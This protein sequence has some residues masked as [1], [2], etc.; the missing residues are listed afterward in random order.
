MIKECAWCG[1]SYYRM[2]ELEPAV[3]ATKKNPQTGQNMKVMAR[4]AIS[5]PVCRS[6][7]EM[8]DRNREEQRQRQEA[9]RQRRRQLR[10]ERAARR[11]A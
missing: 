9:E 2:A 10:E 1:E 11:A 5:V 6:H 3:F 4:R 8:V 7:S